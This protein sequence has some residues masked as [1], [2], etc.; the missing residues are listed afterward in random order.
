MPP[1][2]YYVLIKL[3]F[4]IVIKLLINIFFRLFSAGKCTFVGFISGYSN[5]IFSRF[6]KVFFYS[7]FNIGGIFMGFHFSKHIH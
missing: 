7:F 3:S 5:Y 1:C 4:Q 2:V 6:N